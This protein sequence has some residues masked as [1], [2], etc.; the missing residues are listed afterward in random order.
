MSTTVLLVLLVIFSF[1]VSHLLTRYAARFVTL[2]GAEYILVGA[3]IGPQ[4]PTGL[5]T[6]EALN[7]LQPLVS[8]LLGLVGFLIGMR[9][10]STLH[11]PR[12][13]FIG[14][15]SALG[16]LVAVAA[17]VLGLA[18]RCLKVDEA[19]SDFVLRTQLF[20]RGAY[21]LDLHIPSQSLWLAVSLG[22][23]ASVASPHVVETTAKLLGSRGKIAH[24]LK[25]A[26]TVGQVVAVTALGLVLAAA[27]ATSSA[28]DLGMAVHEWS[29]TAAGV[30][31]VC[32]LLF[33]LF[34][35]R[36]TDTTRIFLATLGAVTF[37]SG[38]GVAV[39][40]SPLFVN[41]LAG[42]TV[43]MT[44]PHAG[45]L[46]R[47]LDRLQHPLFVLLMIFAGAMWSPAPALAWLLPL[48]YVVL[49][50]LARRLFTG[51]AAR[52][53]AHVPQHASRL[54]NGLLSQGT[55][56]VAIAVNF[57]QRYPQLASVVLTTV[58]A[59]ALISDLWST[60][61]LRSLLLDA[62]EFDH[63]AI[64]SGPVSQRAQRAQP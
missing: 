34:I 54:G 10:R 62:G 61:A 8:L 53:A 57:A 25:V 63:Q 37:A 47:E 17:A 48:V 46:L 55:V 30:G 31:V 24:G 50:V 21:A 58:L 59:G 7:K 26:A 18:D 2:S 9:A 6:H 19:A 3:L 23:A 33:S 41:L 12:A 22:A 42:V 15:V 36:E 38:I 29:L 14:T 27:R 35:G 64:G 11:K 5:I 32:G 1:A 43:S 13:V 49:R 16:V 45:T 56:A 40:L 20:Q 60:R 52:F 39:G 51:V 4:L 28:H 44:S